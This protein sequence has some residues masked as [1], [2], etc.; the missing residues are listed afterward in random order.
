M[1]LGL[2]DTVSAITTL[3]ATLTK[4]P[5]SPPSLYI[6]LEGVYLSRHG[7]I[8]ILQL[9]IHP[10]NTTYLID[11]HTLSATAFSTPGSDGQTLGSV[12]SSATIPKVFFDVRNDSD[13]LFS[14]FQISL[15]NVHDIQLME[16]ATRS[17]SRKFVKG[18]LKCI[19]EDLQLTSIENKTWK[20][21]KEKG[22]NLFAPE[23]GGNYAVFNERPM[24]RDLILHCT[25]D[26]QYLPKLWAY[27]QSKLGTGWARKVE[28]AT[29]DR[30]L[31][32]QT[33][34]YNGKG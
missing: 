17:Y 4:L 26:V 6:D 2:I 3:V 33:S 25:Q 14:H 20:A 24:A 15:A 28:T 22:R 30:V 13:A 5:T 19:E 32:S 16:L 18:L 1:C 12:L 31:L 23:R 27:Y 29:E 11:I 9:H 7:S 34:S 21:N 8:S 10:T